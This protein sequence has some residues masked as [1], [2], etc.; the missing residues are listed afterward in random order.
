MPPPWCVVHAPVGALVDDRPCMRT[1]LSYSSTY[2]TNIL[3]SELGA[4]EMW[5]VI[6]T[7]SPG[8]RLE[9]FARQYRHGWYQW[10]DQVEAPALQFA[11]P[12]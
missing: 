10:G 6:E 11:T 4:D 2:R 3:L 12:T 5:S 7:C 9:M 1:G 8:P